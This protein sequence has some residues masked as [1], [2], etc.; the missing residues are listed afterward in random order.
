[1][2][3]WLYQGGHPNRLAAIINRFWAAVHSLGIAPNFL[4]TLEVPG[5]RSG[6][7]IIL[8]LAMTVVDG[9]RYLV[10]MLGT[11]A[12]WV[13][14]V[15]AAGG[16]VMLRHGRREAVR[17]DEVPVDQRAPILKAYLQRAPG[18]RPHLPVDKDAPLGAFERVSAQF[19]VF[20]VVALSALEAASR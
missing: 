10:S 19:P 14:N 17:L 13:Q 20:H 4:V 15:K 18:A 8:P 6:R 12:T 1:M 3:K 2:K 11:Q 16:R 9:E 5:R 7:I